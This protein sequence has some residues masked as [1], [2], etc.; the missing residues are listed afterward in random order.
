MGLTNDQLHIQQE[1]M[2]CVSEPFRS[3]KLASRMFSITGNAGTGKSYLTS[4]IAHALD[5]NL[6]SVKLTAPTH[7]AAA[8]LRQMISELEAST[9]HSHLCLKMSEN[10]DTGA[11]T[12]VSDSKVRPN[13]VDVL[14]VDEFSMIDQEMFDHIVG[15]LRR[16]FAHY[17]VFIGDHFQLPPVNQEFSILDH[18]LAENQFKLT[19]ILRQAA[20]NPVIQ[21][22]QV[23]VQHI[24]QGSSKSAL[25]EQLAEF[26]NSDKITLHIDQVE[27]LEAFISDDNDDAVIL[28]YTNS[29]VDQNNVVARAF[30]KGED[31][32]ELV[33]GDRLVLQ[34]LYEHKSETFQNNQE[35]SVRSAV[36]KQHKQ[37]KV[38][39]WDVKTDQGIIHVIA[40]SARAEWTR[41]LKTIANE[42]VSERDS[43]ARRQKWAIYFRVKKTFAEV[44][45]HYSST[46][47]KSQGSTYPRVYLDLTKMSYVDDNMFSRLAYVG[48]TRTAGELHLLC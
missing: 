38:D 25:M 35:V 9:I 39:Y 30:K 16:G 42:A 48:I 5:D 1:I 13:K 27:F 7:K 23:C 45:F 24:K 14:F 3:K 33:S 29:S 20:D 10:T 11:K 44:K 43:S 18:V 22:S 32:A 28:S 8:V 34:E 46:I 19:E 15:F 40:N 37:H 12:L 6:I 41:I 26:A 47:H 17:V 4:K 2:S 21:M 36:L 31:I